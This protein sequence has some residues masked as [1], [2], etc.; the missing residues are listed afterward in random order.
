VVAVSRGP[1]AFRD[2]VGIG[3]TPAVAAAMFTLAVPFDGLMFDLR[4]ADP[5]LAA[6]EAGT[7]TH[8]LSFS[9]INCSSQPDHIACNPQL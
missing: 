2:Q 4:V 6:W 1:E 7:Q 8:C 3:E 9:A 5:P